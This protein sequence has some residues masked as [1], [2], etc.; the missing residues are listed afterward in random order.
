MRSMTIL[1]PRCLI[2]SVFL[3]LLWWPVAVTGRPFP[4]HCSHTAQSASP[5][6]AGC[7]VARSSARHP[8]NGHVSLPLLSAFDDCALRSFAVEMAGW[9]Q[10]HGTR[11]NWTEL[12]ASAM[13][14]HHCSGHATPSLTADRPSQP[15]SAPLGSTG[16]VAPA[17]AA[18]V[19]VDGST[20][21]RG[22][23]SASAP[24]ASLQAAL[25]AVRS[26]RQGAFPLSSRQQL[27]IT[28]KK[29]IYYLGA[30]VVSHS[31][32]VGALALLPIDSYLTVQ[33]A[34]GERV[35]LSGGTLLTPQWEK[36]ASLAAGVM[37]RTRLDPAV[38]VGS[39]NELYVD[40][41]R[42]VRAK[43]PNGDPST[44]LWTADSRSGYVD[45]SDGWYWNPVQPSTDVFAEPRRPLSEFSTHQWG[46]QGDASVFSPPRNFWATAHP[47]HGSTYIT[48]TMFTSSNLTRR[49]ANWT[50]PAATGQIMLFHQFYWS[51]LTLTQTVTRTL[52]RFC[53][54][55][56]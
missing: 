29:G 50:N 15:M 30:N 23:G 38:D 13:Q 14:L 22:N 54:S 20:T 24:L 17:C 37:Y 45:D 41:R 40:G 49:M 7:P 2:V 53:Y 8:L 31:S 36:H 52:L 19:W 11:S 56:R 46:V 9:L 44:H 28:V 47:P 16:E 6:S 10:P 39:F 34:P 5:G 35:V 51:P 1:T 25:T 26:L 3:T 33:A 18:H 27:C 43:Y 55:T 42:A 4:S 21:S 32:R 48:P 12:A